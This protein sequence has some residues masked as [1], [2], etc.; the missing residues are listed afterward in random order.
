MKIKPIRAAAAV[1]STAP[2]PSRT[3]TNT[4]SREKQHGLDEYDHTEANIARS[5]LPSN[6]IATNETIRSIPQSLQLVNRQTRSTAM[7]IR[8]VRAAT[9][10]LSKTWS[11]CKHQSIDATDLDEG[12]ILRAQ[13][14]PIISIKTVEPV[15]QSPRSVIRAMA[16]ELKSTCA[17][18]SVLSTTHLPSS[19][20]SRVK[21]WDLDDTCSDHD[22]A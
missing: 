22:L 7:K 1:L 5:Q 15:P 12:K 9:S 13:S 21:Q 3:L 2:I 18:T 11:Q 17:A 20:W 14:S 6:E 19:V 10:V 8:P 4:Q 16:M